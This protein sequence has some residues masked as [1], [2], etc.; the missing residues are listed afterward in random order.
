GEQVQECK[1]AVHALHHA[2]I[3]V[4]LD[5]VYNHTAEGNHLGPMLSFKGYDNT[6]YYR[7]VQDAHRYYMDY[8]GTGN[9]INMHDPDVL[10]LLMDS[11]RYWIVDMH[12]GGF[13][14]DPASTLARGLHDVD[15]LSAFFD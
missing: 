4:I 10:E 15:R 3:E 7:T 5:V 13:R 12:V 14:F 9:S 2:G 1:A 8:T 6:A 11:L